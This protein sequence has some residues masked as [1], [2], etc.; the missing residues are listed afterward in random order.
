VIFMKFNLKHQI[1]REYGIIFPPGR[2]ETC[3]NFFHL[4]VE[5]FSITVWKTFFFLPN[6]R[7]FMYSDTKVD[8]LVNV[9]LS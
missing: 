5:T 9:F 1:T 4:R 7:S 8:S 6:K 3:Q 2:W